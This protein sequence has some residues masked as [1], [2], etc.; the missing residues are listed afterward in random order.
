MA[1]IELE[2]EC[3]EVRGLRQVGMNRMI[4]RR[5]GSPEDAAAAL[6]VAQATLH[7]V[8][9]DR[10]IDQV[11]ARGDEEEA[12][13]RHQR[14]REPDQ[15]AI[16]LRAGLEVLAALHEGRRIADHDVELAGM[17]AAELLQRLEGL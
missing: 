6:G 16:A 14:R 11:R 2:G 4:E 1:S 12:A 15:L 8:G 5:T 9:E 10:R 7:L 3:L 17:L 13:A